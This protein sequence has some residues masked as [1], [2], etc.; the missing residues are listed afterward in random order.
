MVNVPLDASQKTFVQKLKYITTLEGSELYENKQFSL[1]FYLTQDDVEYMTPLKGCFNMELSIK[2]YQDDYL[3]SD[4]LRLMRFNYAPHKLQQNFDTRGKLLIELEFNTK[5]EK[6]NQNFIYLQD[7]SAETSYKGVVYP[8]KTVYKHDETKVVT[9]VYS[10]NTLAR[11]K[12]Y[13]L[14]FQGSVFPQDLPQALQICTT[15][16]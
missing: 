15:K 7:M 14:K 12:C 16:C 11:G 2:T 3:S 13:T 8:H 6:L 4:Q 5:L 1:R 10:A 9:L